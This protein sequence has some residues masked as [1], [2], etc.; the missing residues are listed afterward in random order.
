MLV[1]VGT[2]TDAHSLRSQ[3]EIRSESD[4]L[5][6]QSD[7][8]LRISDLE[9]GVRE[10]KSGSVVGEEGD[11]GDDV[12]CVSEK[13]TPTYIIGYKATGLWSAALHNGTFH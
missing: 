6:G 4:C 11:C 12:H 10:E 8:I 13:K 2:R 5:L 9:A 3:A 7:R 1:I